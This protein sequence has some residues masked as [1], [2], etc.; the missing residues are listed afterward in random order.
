[1]DIDIKSETP[2]N[3]GTEWVN[4]PKE[5][6]PDTP[7]Y[8]V[9]V[10]YQNSLTTAVIVIAIIIIFVFIVWLMILVFSD[11]PPATLAPCLPDKCATNIISGVKRCPPPG[12]SINYN[13]DIE[14]CNSRFVCDSSITPLAQ[15]LDGSTST[16]GVCPKN[17][18]CRCLTSG[19]NSIPTYV[20]STFTGVN[21]NPYTSLSNQRLTF[22][23][24]LIPPLS[25]IPNVTTDFFAAPSTWLARSSPGCV[26]MPAVID[27]TGTGADNQREILKNCF[28]DI[29]PCL[30]GSLSY[31]PSSGAQSITSR[32]LNSM[33]FA[34]VRSQPCVKQIENNGRDFILIRD[35]LSGDFLCYNVDDIQ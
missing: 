2:V 29:N 22:T 5:I 10:A 31:I 23:Q 3:I 12:E 35:Y 25:V 8:T 28:N 30:Q 9:E 13:T 32:D 4:P 33:S 19:S 16:T 27:F 21:G 34:C 26:Q 7:K 15:Q 18:E 24:N 11:T 1:M 6:K 14:V 20:V 17:V